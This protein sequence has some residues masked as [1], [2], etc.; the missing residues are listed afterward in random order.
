MEE[1]RSVKER[2]AMQ[3]NSSQHESHLSKRDVNP[4]LLYAAHNFSVPI[5][6]FHNDSLYEP[7]SNDT[8]S[9]RYWFDAS[10]YKQGGPVIVLQAGETSA[11]F[12]L[13]ILQKGRL[14]DVNLQYPV[15][16]LTGILAQLAQATNGVG[17]VLEHR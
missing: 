7:H 14:S 3:T 12:R 17:V 6:H 4:G 10:Y 15:L 13:P 9:L 2:P 11:D 1:V 16:T 5:D 8:F